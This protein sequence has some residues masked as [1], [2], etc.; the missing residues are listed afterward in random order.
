ML[1]Y[2]LLNTLGCLDTIRDRENL[3]ASESVS[4]PRCL[5]IVRDGEAV[6]CQSA[7]KRGVEGIPRRP[8]NGWMGGQNVARL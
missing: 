4:L 3:L 8:K 1:A 6:F 2:V 5:R 7:G